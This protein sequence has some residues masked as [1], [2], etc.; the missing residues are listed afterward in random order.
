MK[1]PAATASLAPVVRPAWVVGFVGH[2]LGIDE[3]RLA[4]LVTA[5][6]RR[7]RDAVAAAGGELHFYA[8]VADGADLL[9]LD[10]AAALG[11]AQHV[12]LP[13]PEEDFLRPFHSPT[14]RARAKAR[15]EAI[16]AEPGRH[17]W[18]VAATSLAVPAAYFEADVGI[19]EACDVLL[20]V[21]DGKPE[22]GLGGTAQL[23][24]LARAQRRPIVW[25][26]R[27][28]GEVTREGFAADWPAP[29]AKLQFFAAKG[30]VRIVASADAAPV[31]ADASVAENPA[32]SGRIK[33]RLSG[34]ANPDAARFRVAIGMFSILSALATVVGALAGLLPG[35]TA[36]Q[37][38]AGLLVYEVEWVLLM[39]VLVF[40]LHRWRKQLRN[41]W[42]D[43]RFGAELYRGLSTSQPLLD[44]LHPPVAAL[45]PE[46]RRYALTLGLL[47]H[48]ERA[49]GFAFATFRTAYRDQRLT[50]QAAHFA[51]TA[52]TSRWKSRAWEL[53]T[54]ATIVGAVGMISLAYVNRAWVLRWQEAY[55][56]V[57][58]TLVGLLPVLLPA[59][60]S[61][62]SALPLILDDDRRAAR[63]PEIARRLAALAVEADHQHTEGSLRRF[64]AAT[65]ALLLDE[66]LEWY[67]VTSRADSN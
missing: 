57:G 63:Y 35:A 24:A 47:L 59:M 65:E 30:I 56:L 18:R 52:R 50:D 39:A 20:A 29:D 28:T 55:G 21:W 45:R 41:E 3:A 17:T 22:G 53:T 26:H 67:S 13:M 37:Q 36:G 64:V 62:A 42:I 66:L 7:L 34:L 43:A 14:G 9:A 51:K 16:R 44:P 33:A 40:K 48:R 54:D 25:I 1:T 32:V 23:V 12:V 6:L 2:R 38:A 5:E 31:D 15:L 49:P 19:V 8:S 27:D 46:W 60:V 61:L 4:P 11:L 58:V 10:A